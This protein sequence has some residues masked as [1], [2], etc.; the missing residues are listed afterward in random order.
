LQLFKVG[1]S[2]LSAVPASV[3][4]NMRGVVLPDINLGRHWALYLIK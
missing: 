3:Q 2:C 1:Y 4:N